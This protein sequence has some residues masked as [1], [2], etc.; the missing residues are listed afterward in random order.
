MWPE[1]LSRIFEA[2]WLIEATIKAPCKRFAIDAN[3]GGGPL[4]ISGR[5]QQQAL[6][7]N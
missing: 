6:G 3:C 7:T 2:M 4:H 5:L 1:L